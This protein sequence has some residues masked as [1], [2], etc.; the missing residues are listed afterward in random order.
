M[1]EPDVSDIL[2]RAN[3]THSSEGTPH[4]LQEHQN[5]QSLDEHQE[6]ESVVVEENHS[7]AGFL[8][9]MLQHGE[10]SLQDATAQ[11]EA[12]TTSHFDINEMLGT[13]SRRVN[14]VQEMVD[15]LE[16][17]ERESIPEENIQ[18][19]MESVQEQ[20]QNP[21][22][23]AENIVLPEEL[24]K[25]YENVIARDETARFSSAEWFK[26][27]QRFII[28]LAGLGGIGSWTALLLAR[29]KP[30]YMYNWD[31]DNVEMVNLA[32]QLYGVSDIG[33]SKVTAISKYLRENANYHNYL[34]YNNRFTSRNTG[35]A[36]M[37]CGFDSMRA[38]KDFFISWKTF[39]GRYPKK[40]ETLFIDGRLTA[41]EFQVFCMTGEDSALMRKYEQ[42][43]LFE[44]REASQEICSFKQT[45][46][47]ANMIAG[48]IVNLYV[49]FC[50][51]L[52]G[53]PFKKALPFITKYN[54]DM[55]MFNIEY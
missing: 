48:V 14:E 25:A 46:Y 51:N 7:L 17:T 39:V 9:T 42:E 11:G 20:N 2:R 47:L 44:D 53:S 32:G 50:A 52:C 28:T 23:S 6:L 12:T 43:Y 4:P 55:M 27:A 22:N 1:R 37:I 24:Q 41:T 35:N 19:V 40:Q 18:E 54:T 33:R 30:A 26:T 34:E 38:R 49:N 5:V 45:A 36:I 31:P 13:I 16:Q 3:N 21:E 29:L 8:R 15:A 10:I